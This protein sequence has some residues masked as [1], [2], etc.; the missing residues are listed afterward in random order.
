MNEKSKKVIMLVVSIVIAMTFI[1]SYLNSDF[2]STTPTAP[3]K[4]AV[5][6]Q[7]V[8]FF[9]S[10]NA[11]I[12]NYTSSLYVYEN[13]TDVTNASKLTSL[14]SSLSSALNVIPSYGE[15]SLPNG[16]YLRLTGSAVSASQT[17]KKEFGNEI[18]LKS[19]A[20]VNIIGN[21]TSSL[22]V[23]ENV[24]GASNLTSLNSNLASAFIALG[25]ND[26]Y[27]IKN[28]YDIIKVGSVNNITESLRKEFGNK[29]ILKPTITV[30][31]V[32]MTYS[33]KYGDIGIY[34]NATTLYTLDNVSI[35]AVNSTIPVSIIATVTDNDKPYQVVLKPIE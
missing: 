7:P 33:S 9:G 29:I 13:T 3:S 23:Y 11:I 18:I 5:K 26:E 2:N 17:L 28:G 25:I 31:A 32:P 14:N 10:A 19:D 21:Y 6:L 8:P 4:S 15:T 27:P 22:Y 12:R 1:S 16:Y 30:D 34:F 24:T 35:S 20:L